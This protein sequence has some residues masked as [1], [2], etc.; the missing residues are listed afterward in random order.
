M[1][2]LLDLL[3]GIPVL[4]LVFQ[5]V[6]YLIDLLPQMAPFILRA[7]TPLAFGAL[8]GVMCERSGVVN[9]AI[10][11]TMLI[12][13]FSG[14]IVSVAVAPSLASVTISIFGANAG[15]LVAVGGAIV[16]AM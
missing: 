11:G 7:A 4:G 12:G 10:E 2:G 14:W 6:G 1:E 16:A 13:A 5:L 8:C 15:L 9:I 3:Y